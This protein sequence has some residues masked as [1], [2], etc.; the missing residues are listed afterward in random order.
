[1]VLCY[2][3]VWAGGGGMGAHA[4][5]NFYGRAEIHASFGAKHKNFGKIMLCPENFLYACVNYGIK[6]NFFCMSGK[7]LVCFRKLRDIRETFLVCT[8]KKF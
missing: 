1:M 3:G 7:F 8:G 5:P 2:I 6:G 4:L